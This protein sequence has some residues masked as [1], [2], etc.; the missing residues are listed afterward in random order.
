[1]DKQILQTNQITN[2]RETGILKENEYAFL[3]G[4]LVIA[5]NVETSS[6]RVLGKASELLHE[7]KK[8]V[9]LG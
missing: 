6:K 3:A 9:L 8:R 4:D 5:E 2:L 1:M 7:G